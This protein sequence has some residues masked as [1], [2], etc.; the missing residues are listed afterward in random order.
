MIDHERIH[1]TI[2][3]MDRQISAQC[4][5]RRK[6]SMILPSQLGGPLKRSRYLDAPRRTF[7][8][9]DSKNAFTPFPFT[10]NSA[11]WSN[12]YNRPALVSPPTYVENVDSRGN[13]PLLPAMDDRA[14]R[15]S[16]QSPAFAPGRSFLPYEIQ[17]TPSVIESSLGLRVSPICR[18]THILPEHQKDFENIKKAASALIHMRFTPITSETNAQQHVKDEVL[19][20][21]KTITK[22]Q[23]R[24]AIAILKPRSPQSD[25]FSPTS[26]SSSESAIAADANQIEFACLRLGLA[27]DSSELNSLHC[28]VRS[29]LLELYMEDERNRNCTAR[30]GIRCVHCAR[31]FRSESSNMSSFFP[32][33]L[34]DIYRTVCTWQRVH[35]QA[36]EHIPQE[37]RDKYWKLKSSDKTRGKTRYW[38]TSALQM[39]LCDLG[40]ERVGI[41]F[42]TV[43]RKKQNVKQHHSHS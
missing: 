24:D 19:Y 42:P 37:I 6:L 34:Q 22:C 14:V 8:Q 40:G 1:L 20:Q 25:C 10:R 30:V 7:V 21:I 28:F 32:K 27:S 15:G 35:F 39:G 43:A 38:V 23:A 26:Y 4:G 17:Y 11:G 16:L 41:C 9:K 3:H 36:C 29:E 12:D 31:A 2:D 33:S 18:S 5:S 13:G